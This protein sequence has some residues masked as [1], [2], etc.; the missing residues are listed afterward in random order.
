MHFPV[1]DVVKNVRYFLGVVKRATGNVRDPLADSNKKETS[2]KP[3]KSLPNYQIVLFSWCFKSMRSPA[4]CSA[5][6]KGRASKYR[7]RSVCGAVNS[8]LY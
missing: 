1:T 8:R 3:G 4:S 5:P 6:S 7:M 2:Q